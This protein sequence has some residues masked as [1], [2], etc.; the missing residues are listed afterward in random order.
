MPTTALSVFDSTLEKTNLWLND[1]GQELTWDSKHGA[2]MALRSTLHALRDRLPVNE[3][4][5]LGAQ[6][7]MLIRGMYYEGWHPPGKPLKF[8]H[9]D[10]FLDHV[11]T[12]CRADMDLPVDEMVKGVLRVVSRRLTPGEVSSVM[13]ALPE[14]L[15]TFW[16]EP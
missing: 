6:L 5:K 2:Y 4:V 11:R 10:E 13:R 8:R 9:A 12:E 14:T 15:R 16:P 7:P 3:A 1:I